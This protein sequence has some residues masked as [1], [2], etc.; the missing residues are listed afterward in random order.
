LTVV[1]GR[2]VVSKEERGGKGY[3]ETDEVIAGH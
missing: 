3:K 1:S 2:E